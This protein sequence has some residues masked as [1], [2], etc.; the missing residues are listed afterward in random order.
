MS[1]KRKYSF[2]VNFHLMNVLPI[3]TIFATW[4]IFCEKKKQKCKMGRFKLYARQMVWLP[5]LNS[6][7]KIF[8]QFEMD[9]DLF[10][11]FFQKI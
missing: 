3:F 9:L 6:T 10:N 11:K 4:I 8:I 2:F 7:Q 1:Q 5:P